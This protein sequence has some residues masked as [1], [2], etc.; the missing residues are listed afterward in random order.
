[1][2]LHVTFWVFQHFLYIKYL[3]MINLKHLRHVMTWGYS[4]ALL[5]VTTMLNLKTMLPDYKIH[6]TNH[7]PTQAFR[8]W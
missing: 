1:M 8:G 3:L 2:A 4:L 7:T 5:N 6:L